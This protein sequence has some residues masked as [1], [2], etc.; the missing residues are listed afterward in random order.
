MGWRPGSTNGGAGIRAQQ[1]RGCREA[2]RTVRTPDGASPP[3]YLLLS[4]IASPSERTDCAAQGGSL[5]AV[6]DYE[7]C[8]RYP[9]APRQHPSQNEGCRSLR[10]ITWTNCTPDN[11][12]CSR[13]L[14][15]SNANATHWTQEVRTRTGATSWIWRARR[16]GKN[17][18]SSAHP[19]PK[20]WIETCNAKRSFSAASSDAT[21][22]R[23]F[24]RRRLAAPTYD[25]TRARPCQKRL[26]ANGRQYDVRS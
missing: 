2:A 1:G 23:V 9:V 12:W 20:S 18:P 24:C 7:S 21:Y 3:R 11:A 4:I 19:S 5:L 14:S 16:C 6:K 26:I 10:K 15:G 25:D 22:P 13:K 8:R 17:R